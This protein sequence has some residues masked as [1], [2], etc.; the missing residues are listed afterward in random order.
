MT[1]LGWDRPR[2]DV[3]LKAEMT[4][5]EPWKVPVLFPTRLVAGTGREELGIEDGLNS[6]YLELPRTT[7]ALVN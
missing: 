2:P 3:A 6:F 1:Q 4:S 5:T 7:A